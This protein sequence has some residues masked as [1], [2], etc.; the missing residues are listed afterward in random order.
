MAHRQY[1]PQQY[2][3]CVIKHGGS[4]VKAASELGV[5]A[6]AVLENLNICKKR[7]LEI[8]ISPYHTNRTEY[9]IEQTE[10][11]HLAAPEKFLVKGVSTLVDGDGNI[12]AQ[13]IKTQREAEE[14]LKA[15]V[16]ALKE[17][18]AQTVPL[19]AIAAPKS[20]V[21]SLLTVYPIGDAHF[22][23]HAWGEETGE[24]FDL[25][26]AEDILVSAVQRVV[27]SG[28][29]S[30]TALIVN[31]GDYIHIDDGTNRTP[32]SGHAL[33]ADSR[34]A[35]IIRVAL[36]ALVT[37]IY[38]ALRRHEN[39]IVISK[40][41]NHDPHSSVVLQVALGLFF[42]NNPRVTIDQGPAPFSY[43]E[44]GR[45]LIGVTHGDKVKLEQLGGI[46]AAD[47]PEAWGRTQF[48][49][50]IT[51]HVHTRLVFEGPGWTGESF[52]TLTPGDGYAVS[53][54]Y[55]SGRDIYGIV[56]D[57]KYGEVERHRVDIAQ[58]RSA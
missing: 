33:D 17:T 28:P 5:S 42:E 51:G 12:R 25:K 9:L 4:R 56:F 37:S 8:P 45:N 2:L 54:G 30:K 35:K 34:Y 18:F 55:R 3:D 6:R 11:A 26:I 24:D 58:V 52:R 22:G 20:T 14:R 49:V 53:H 15:L 46:M 40:P 36:R 32:A 1:T 29:R 31:V 50:W 19:A 38:L 48:R 44:F 10:A 27:R 13:W 7:G 41:G 21:G 39:V 23:M 57:E 43:H 47:R 16:D